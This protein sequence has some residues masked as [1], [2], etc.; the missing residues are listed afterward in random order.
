MQVNYSYMT[1]GAHPHPPN[2]LP[3]VVSYIAR[4]EGSLAQLVL[5]TATCEMAQHARN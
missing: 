3:M 4:L 1:S 5:V 2:T